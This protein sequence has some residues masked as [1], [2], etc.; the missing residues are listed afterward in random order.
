MKALVTGSTGI[1]GAHIVR[2]LLADGITVRALVRPTSDTTAL[3]GLPV[4]RCTGDV[5]R[6]DSLVE[7]A[8][9]CDLVFHAAAAFDYLQSRD[10]LRNT[11]VVGTEN[12]IRA[13]HQARVA[14]VVVT[15]SSVVLGYS[16]EPVPVSE[17]VVPRPNDTNAYVA[18][19]LAQESA[20]IETA[21]ALRVELLLALPTLTIGAFD[22]RLGTSNAILTGYLNDPFRATFP[23]GINL[24]AATDVAIGHLLIARAGTP[25]R[26]YVLGSENLEWE[27]AHRLVSELCG[28][29]GPHLKA[30]HTMSYLGAAFEELKAT[31]MRTRPTTSREQAK[32]VGRYYWYASNA[33]SALG[34]S[35]M[36]SREALLEALG[37]LTASTHVSREARSRI[38][39]SPDIFAA[40][41]RTAEREARLR[42]M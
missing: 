30:N 28:T 22:T 13:A 3:A 33:A 1:V 7:C 42:E 34:F 4:E 40:R 5:L 11:A 14:R 24:I 17:D 16:N 29:D 8:A 27:A 2:A 41:R 35:P 12:V 39:L 18:S 38:R 36:R 26:R 31:V 19:K 9:G 15:S 37:W 6:A 20:A 32:M 10:D 23:G 25:F 21:K